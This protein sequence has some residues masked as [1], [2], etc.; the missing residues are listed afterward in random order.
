MKRTLLVLML[1]ALGAGCGADDA[2]EDPAPAPLPGTVTLT[3]SVT[4]GVRK[5]PNL[6]SPL[7]GVVYGSL[8]KREDVTLSGPIKGAEDVAPVEVAAVDL[9][10]SNASQASWKSPSIT[11]GTYTFLGFYDVNGDGA[12]TKDPNSGDPVTLP[13]TNEFTIEAGVNKE[14]LVAFDLVLN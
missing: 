11:P 6:K 9:Q 5:S 10:A 1:A 3:F 12:T 2:A 8:Y 7:V 14:F 4:E 13:I